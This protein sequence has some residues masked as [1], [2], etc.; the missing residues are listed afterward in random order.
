MA[1]SNSMKLYRLWDKPN[2]PFR[3]SEIPH[4]WVEIPL[5]APQ[6]PRVSEGQWY[7]ESQNCEV[8]EVVVSV[9]YDDHEKPPPASPPKMSCP[10]CGSLMSFHH[11][12][13]HFGIVPAAE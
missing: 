2:R 5:E 11:Y 3:I 12:V 10:A 1:Q 6:N 8:R 7:C 4:A 13:Q 9:K